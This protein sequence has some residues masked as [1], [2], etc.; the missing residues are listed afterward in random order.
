MYPS[1]HRMCVNAPKDN[2]RCGCYN[3]PTSRVHSH[4][5]GGVDVGMGVDGTGH[6]LEAPHNRTNRNIGDRQGDKNL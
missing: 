4:G 1:P 6:D 3:E 5:E 2:G